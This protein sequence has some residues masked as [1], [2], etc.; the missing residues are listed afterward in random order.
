RPAEV[1]LLIA[2]PTKAREQ[3]GWEPSVDFEQLVK[4]MVDAD[5]ALL[6][7]GSPVSTA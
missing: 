6:R 3:L 2:D 4:L 1:D 7:E 5:L